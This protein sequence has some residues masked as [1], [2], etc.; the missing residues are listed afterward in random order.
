MKWNYALLVALVLLTGCTEELIIV[1]GSGSSGG[2]SNNDTFCLDLELL[3]GDTATE[4]FTYISDN[5]SSDNQTYY[6]NLTNA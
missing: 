3:F 5:R 1:R 2:C 6:L 4:D